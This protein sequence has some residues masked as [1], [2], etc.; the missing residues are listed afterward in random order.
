MVDE[1]EVDKISFDVE[2]R[3]DVGAE[4]EEFIRL[5]HS[6][7]YGEAELLYR[8]CLEQHL[9]WFPVAAEYADF[10]LRRCEF[11]ALRTFCRAE[12]AQ[13]TDPQERDVIGLMLIIA[14]L[15][16][17]PDISFSRSL[18]AT[19]RVWEYMYLHSNR[20]KEEPSDSEVRTKKSVS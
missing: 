11:A 5:N 3:E 16:L 18:I 4:L 1:E 15:E 6:G 10:L 7:N 14:E 12:T 9:K 19:N 8:E 13:F 17:A 20:T 2:I